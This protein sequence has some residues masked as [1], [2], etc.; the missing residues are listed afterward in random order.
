MSE[1]ETEGPTWNGEQW[2]YPSETEMVWNGEEWVPE[3]AE[4]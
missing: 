2:I 3:K 1:S 4:S